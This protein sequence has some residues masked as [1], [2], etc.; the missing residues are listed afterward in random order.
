MEVISTKFHKAEFTFSG[1][2]P[3]LKEVKTKDVIADGCS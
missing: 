1:D 2:R 3:L